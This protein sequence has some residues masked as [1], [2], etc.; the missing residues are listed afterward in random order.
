[1]EHMILDGKIHNIIASLGFLVAL[2]AWA[3]YVARHFGL[4]FK[5]SHRRDPRKS[6]LITPGEILNEKDWTPEGIRVQR[7]FLKTSLVAA[8]LLLALWLVLDAIY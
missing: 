1:M 7:L 4:V 3:V 2:L 5:E 6:L 8:A